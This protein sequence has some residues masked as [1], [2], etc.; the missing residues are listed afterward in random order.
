MLFFV[1]KSAKSTDKALQKKLCRKQSKPTPDWK[2]GAARPPEAGR[3]ESG[4]LQSGLANKARSRKK[5]CP[6]IQDSEQFHFLF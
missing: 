5:N 4:A 3:S 2:G 6:E 1:K